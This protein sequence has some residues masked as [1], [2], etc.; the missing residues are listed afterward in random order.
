MTYP[1]KHETL[2]KCWFNVG[3]SSKTVGHIELTVGQRF[4]FAGI[5]LSQML[6]TYIIIL[7]DFFLNLSP[8]SKWLIYIIRYIPVSFCLKTVSCDVHSCVEMTGV[9]TN[10][11][12]DWQVI[13]RKVTQ[14][15]KFW[16]EQLILV[17][18]NYNKIT[19]SIKIAV[20]SF[21]A[22]SNHST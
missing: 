10:E 11:I 15:G 12:N 13:V 20:A 17:K 3:P 16:S 18:S 6:H 2:T 8:H 5:N 14:S 4:V 22:H 1:S 19:T 21:T 9:P 7:E